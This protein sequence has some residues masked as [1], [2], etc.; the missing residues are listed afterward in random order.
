M[1]A[2]E[3]TTGLEGGEELPEFSVRCRGLKGLPS[4]HGLEGGLAAEQQRAELRH[5]RREGRAAAGGVAEASEFVISVPTRQ[6]LE[7]TRMPAAQGDETAAVLSV[8]T[9]HTCALSP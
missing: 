5:R 9:S 6:Q 8:L 7:T 2:E 3:A 1:A 4:D